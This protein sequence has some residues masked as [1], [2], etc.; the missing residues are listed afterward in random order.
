[1]SQALLTPSL[2][3]DIMIQVYSQADCVRYQEL[4]IS[5][6]SNQLGIGVWV[7]FDQ[8]SQ[9]DSIFS[10]SQTNFKDEPTDWKIIF[11]IELNT[12]WSSQDDIYQFYE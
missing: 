8:I 10:I 6:E 12:V 9:I 7:S 5:S 1:M 11:L 3:S 4:R 2:I